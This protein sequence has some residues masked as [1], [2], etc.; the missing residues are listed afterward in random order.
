M[1]NMKQIGI[2]LLLLLV[3]VPM[4]SRAETV[5]R[6]GTD[7]SVEEDQIVDGDYYVSV[8]PIGRTVMSGE[9][10]G[11]MYAFG[12][13]VTVNGEVGSDVAIVAGTSQI[14]A[15]INDDVRIVAGEVVLADEVG[16]DVFVMSGSLSVLSTA[17]ITGN[18]YFFGGDATIEGDVDGSVQGSAQHMEINATIGGAV[19]V[20]APAGLVLGNRAHIG[21]D[22][23]YSSL[24]SLVRGTDTS[25]EGEVIKGASVTATTKERARAALVPIFILLFASLSLYLLFKK[26]LETLI[27]SLEQKFT[28]N[29][30]L[31]SAVIV[32]GP[33]TAVFLMLTVLGLFV[34]LMTSALVVLLYV[35]GLSLSGMVLGAFIMCTMTKKLMVTLPTIFVG[36]AAMQLLLLIPVAG[37]ITAFVIFA[38][39]VGAVTYRLYEAVA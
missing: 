39:T 2:F 15:P 17:H 3:S 16:G 29:L 37:P 23:R 30:F 5:L 38:L 26:D 9:V 19:D 31:G 35:A 21:G 33:L 7:I 32:L 11:D 24:S 28:R 8:G 34:G 25:V 12:A 22:V 6:T 18:I 27:V 1:S 36:T 20:S 4:I 14:H 10:T 13:S